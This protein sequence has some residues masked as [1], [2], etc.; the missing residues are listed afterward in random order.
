MRMPMIALLAITIVAATHWKSSSATAADTPA[1]TTAPAVDLATGWSLLQEGAA[2]GTIE[3]DAKHGSNPSPHVLHL[4]VTKTADPGEGRAGAVSNVHFAVEKGEWCEVTFTAVTERGSIGM[5]FSLESSDGKVLA[6]TTLPEIGRGR[7]RR[8]ATQPASIP[9]VW[10]SY[11]VSLHV[12]AADPGAHLV[13][14]PIEPTNIWL[15]G[16]TL[17][18]RAADH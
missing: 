13:I 14:T 16:M 2:H 17:T 11:S 1:P 12:R 4:A 6:R 10:P 5:V 18:S 7:G 15:D 3:T 8:G 9:T